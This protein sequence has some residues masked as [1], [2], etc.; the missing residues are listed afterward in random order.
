MNNRKIP[1]SFKIILFLFVFSVIELSDQ[2]F[3]KKWNLD[4]VYI[5][6]SITQGVQLGKPE[7][8]A[9]P[10]ASSE[11]L[12]HQSGV[13]DVK[14]INQGRSGY[15]TVDYLPSGSGA[16]SEVIAAAHQLH[17]DTNRLL[18]FTI[19][20]GTNDSAENGPNGSPVD[21]AEYQ[22]NLQRIADK[23]LSEFPQCKIVLLQ[24]IWYS[25]NTYNSARYMSEGLAR[26]QSYFPELQSLVSKYSQ[27]RP[28]KVF[29]GD[30]KGFAYFRNNYLTDLIPESGNAGTFYLHPNKKG[31][32]V[33]GRLWGEAIYES[34]FKEAV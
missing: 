16:L 30:L 28:D 5:G 21:P 20:L 26:L 2:P 11:Y 3:E 18:I 19:S 13:G 4:I 6:N 34:I 33:L 29:L 32:N 22:K 23:L 10:A 7:E 8:E 31:A 27:T 9:P 25:P 1:L 14:F 12:K 15:T 24:P 17:K